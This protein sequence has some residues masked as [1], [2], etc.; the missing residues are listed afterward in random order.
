MSVTS[1]Q[2]RG[3]EGGDM[4]RFVYALLLI[5]F[6]RE[7]FV[8]SFENVELMVVNNSGTKITIE[9]CEL[10]GRS[11]PNC[12]YELPNKETVFFETKP[13]I[14]SKNNHFDLMTLSDK[15]SKKFSCSFVKEDLDCT[16]EMELTKDGL[17][18]GST[19]ISIYR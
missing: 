3:M 15:G 9:S 6:M 10:N 19:C 17:T 11:I 1:E 2:Q 13:R 5:F 16:E 12:R 4:K 7:I 8:F 18:C 14:Y